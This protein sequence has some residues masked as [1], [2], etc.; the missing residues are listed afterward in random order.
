MERLE[1]ARNKYKEVF[2][3]EP[4]DNPTAPDELKISDIYEAISSGVKIDGPGVNYIKLVE[5]QE[6]LYKKKF[7]RYP[8]RGISSGGDPLGYAAELKTA[9][10]TGEP[11]EIA[12]FE[13]GVF[14]D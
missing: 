11:Y 3:E 1:V 6:D 14:H 4:E 13:E 8:A 7:G 5:V 2:G 10:A 12:Q 9:I